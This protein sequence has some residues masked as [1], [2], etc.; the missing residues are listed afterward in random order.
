MSEF[1]LEPGPKIGGLLELVDEA[2][3]TGEISTPDEAINLVKTIL[4][5]EDNNQYQEGN[6]EET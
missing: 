5:T 1:H 4:E 3:A 2:R 6:R